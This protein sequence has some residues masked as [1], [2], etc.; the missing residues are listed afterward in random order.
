MID[1]ISIP[2]DYPPDFWQNLLREISETGMTNYKI[3]VCLGIRINQ[4]A[5]IR[6]GSEP[7]ARIAR[8]ILSIHAAKV[9]HETT[10]IR[11]HKFA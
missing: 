4:L 9:S 11:M 10:N 2:E 3:S 1:L 8:R 5:R 7:K 6:A